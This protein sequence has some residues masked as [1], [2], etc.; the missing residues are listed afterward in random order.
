MIHCG[1]DQYISKEP[2]DI[3]LLTSL[4][5]PQHQTTTFCQINIYDM[6]H[7]T[8]LHCTVHLGQAQ[9]LNFSMKYNFQ[10]I[11][12][13]AVQYSAVQCS[14]VQCSAV[15]SQ[16]VIELKFKPYNIPV[17]LNRCTIMQCSAAAEKSI[18]TLHHYHFAH[19]CTSHWHCTRRYR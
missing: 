12:Y 11:Q 16:T 18:S 9:T 8:A 5:L 1:R 7:C 13:S 10:A 4:L 2:W 3:L 19:H 14:A 17:V 6:E 15:R